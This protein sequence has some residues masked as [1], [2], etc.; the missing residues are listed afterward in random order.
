MLMPAPVQNSLFARLKLLFSGFSYLV[1]WLGFLAAGLVTGIVALQTPIVA[2]ALAVFVSLGALSS[3]GPFAG[4]RGWSPTALALALLFLLVSGL[5]LSWTVNPEMGLRQWVKFAYTLLPFALAVG[6]LPRIKARAAARLQWASILGV[7]I[8]TAL[9]VYEIR[10]GEPVHRWVAGLKPGQALSINEFSMALVGMAMISMP[11]VGMLVARGQRNL[12]L[13]LPL[14]YTAV[15]TRSESQTALMGMGCGLLMWLLAWF[16]PRI[17]LWLARIMVVVLTMAP[18]PIAYLLY[19]M[20]LSH[21]SWLMLSARHRIEVWHFAADRIMASPWTGYG[22]ESAQTTFP[23]ASEIS[24]FLP[25]D[26]NMVHRHPHDMFLQTWYEFGVGGGL[27]LCVVGL[28]LL[29]RMRDWPQLARVTGMATMAACISMV[30]VTSFSAWH[31]WFVCSQALALFGCLLVLAAPGPTQ[32][33]ADTAD[34]ASMAG[35][36]A[37]AQTPAADALLETMTKDTAHGPG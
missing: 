6:F 1:V 5:S 36:S 12:A 32:S 16:W 11:V 20:G 24:S 31:T 3:A 34:A 8:G 35:A 10:N 23:R 15:L 37:G 19:G 9:L 7:L 17:S 14:A 2:L 28:L 18:V 13:V 27:V 22:L 26:L 25:P 21:D 4:S 29:Q 30:S 33:D